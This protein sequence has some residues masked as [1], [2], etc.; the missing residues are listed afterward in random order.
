MSSVNKVWVRV[1]S[2]WFWYVV[3]KLCV[4]GVHARIVTLYVVTHGVLRNA[5]HCTR[6][7]RFLEYA[8][9]TRNFVSFLLLLGREQICRPLERFTPSKSGHCRYNTLETRLKV[10]VSTF[11]ADQNRS[12]RCCIMRIVHFSSLLIWTYLWSK[13][14]TYSLLVPLWTNHTN[15]GQVSKNKLLI[16]SAVY[17]LNLMLSFTT[18]GIERVSR[19]YWI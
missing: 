17:T 2:S 14:M 18:T 9:I 19:L 13:T 4:L 15:C 6:R 11:E 8:L 16:S 5:T 7:R 10:S 1:Y 3:I 12:S